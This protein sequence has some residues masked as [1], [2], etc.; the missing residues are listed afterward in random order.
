MNNAHTA[1]FAIVTVSFMA[2]AG[3]LIYM[4]YVSHNDSL[5]NLAT[6]IIG[7]ILGMWLPSPIQPT[8]QVPKE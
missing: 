1:L 4:S 6:G 7:T 8:V 2:L 5:L 3:F